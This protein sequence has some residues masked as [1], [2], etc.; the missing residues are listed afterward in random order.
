MVAAWEEQG[1]NRNIAALDG[2]E[3]VSDRMAAVL[4]GEMTGEPPVYVPPPR[5]G[6]RVRPCVYLPFSPLCSGAVRSSGRLLRSP[7]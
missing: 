6:K 2:E 4:V 3:I 7:L 1:N 5:Q